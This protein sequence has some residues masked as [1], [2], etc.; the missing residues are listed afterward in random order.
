M[1][2]VFNVGRGEGSPCP[3]CSRPFGR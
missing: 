2:E 3:R 1:G